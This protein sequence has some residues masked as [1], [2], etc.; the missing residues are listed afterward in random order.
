MKPNENDRKLAERI[1]GKLDQDIGLYT[2]GRS[3]D[4]MK[5]MFIEI[6]AQ[7]LADQRE[8][9]SAALKERI[10]VLEKALGEYLTESKRYYYNQCGHIE[11]ALSPDTAEKEE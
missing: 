3:Y 4:E 7:I 6:T 8:E 5:S 2:M 9:E 11:Q 10:R 1:L